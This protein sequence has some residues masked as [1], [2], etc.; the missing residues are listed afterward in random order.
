M[1]WQETQEQALRT[2]KK[3]LT[4]RPILCLPDFTKNFILRTDASD[5]GI[6]AVLLQEQEEDKRPVAYA[7][8]KLLPF[9][10]S[11]FILQDKDYY[12]THFLKTMAFQA[13]LFHMKFSTMTIFIL[14]KFCANL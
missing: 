9:Q 11:E 1:V 6:G 2:L 14:C 5:F 12:F 13:K 4:S 3:S 7:S 8:R 10:T